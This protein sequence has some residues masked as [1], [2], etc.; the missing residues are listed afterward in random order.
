MPKRIRLRELSAGEVDEIRRLANA[1]KESIEVVRRARL[2]AYLLDHPDVP[3]SQAGLRVGFGSNA[4]GTQWVKRMNEEGIAGL[5]NRAKSGRPVT[6]TEAVRSQ[7][8]DL[9]L[10]KPESL[11]YPFALWTLARLQTAFQERTDLHLSRSTLWEWLKAEGL[12]WK[13][14]QSWFHAPAQ[15]DPEF[16]EKRGP[17]SG[18]M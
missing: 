10:Q 12:D 4:T 8:I 7:V 17:S 9:A 16:V 1:R 18:P 15:H 3:A 13:R 2:I 5:L 6:H 11:G 14:Q